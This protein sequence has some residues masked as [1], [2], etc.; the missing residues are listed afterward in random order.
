VKG[1]LALV[2][3]G[4]GFIGSALVKKLLQ[5]NYKVRVLD[6]TKPLK[7]GNIKSSRLEFMHGSIDDKRIVNEAVMKVDVVHHLALAGNDFSVRDYEALRVNIEGALNLLNSAH[8]ENVKHFLFASS[9]AI[10]GNPR[11][12]PIDEEHPCNPEESLVG[13]GPLYGVVKLTTEKLCMVFWHLYKFP[14]TVFRI[15]PVFDER[16]VHGLDDFIQKGIKG[17][18]VQV[19]VGEKDA[20]VHVEDVVQAFLKATVNSNAYGQVF[21]VENP[22][23]SVEE[24]ELAMSILRLLGSR[25]EIKVLHDPTRLT[26]SLDKV[27]KIEGLLRWKPMKGREELEK[28]LKRYVTS[29][30]VY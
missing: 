18:T 29:A 22:D 7:L 25:S 30:K 13:P 4:S 1:L 26:P 2:T 27:E 3:G 20:F 14:V 8:T 6:T 9:S 23:A 24:Y 28:A 17:E 12:T 21:N 16:V 15:G 11:Y 5:E 19:T 10:Y